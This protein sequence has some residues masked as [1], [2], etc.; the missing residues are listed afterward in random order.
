[1]L[2]KIVRIDTDE[3]WP[4]LWSFLW[5]F[6]LLCG[7]Y[8]IRP[9]RDTLASDI[10]DRENLFLYTFLATL[11]ASPV[12][13]GMV[14]TF[15]RR[16]IVG[17]AYG[18]FAT[19]LVLFCLLF[20][21]HAGRIPLTISRVF[22]VWI[23][24]YNMFVVSIFWS[25][26]TDVFTSSQGKRLFA[27]IAAGGTLGSICGAA[28]TTAYAR[29]V[30]LS[31]LVLPSIALLCAS[32][33]FSALLNKSRPKSTTVVP[34]DNATAHGALGGI[35]D[36]IREVLRTPYLLGICGFLLLGLTCA[37]TVYLQQFPIINATLPDRQDR[38][39]LFAMM[40]FGV[41][42]LTLLIQI[43]AT[44]PLLRWLGVAL[45]FCLVPLCYVFAF[46][47][48]AL[49]PSLPVIVAAVIGQR[50]LEFGMAKP[51]RELL[52]TV[53]SRGQRYKA[54]NFIDTSVVRGGDVLA[55]RLYGYLQKTQELSVPRI[56]LMMI[57]MAL[58]WTTA[59]WF[60]GRAQV[61]RAAQLE[62][63]SQS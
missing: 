16:R 33:V 12:Y 47:V 40:D 18:V 46:G 5:F 27:V 43:V 9:I 11:V 45:T 2:R 52:F 20:M 1:L 24:V 42:I 44:A 29:H 49:S 14:S 7:Y 32:I 25:F 23:G 4:L 13:S 34:A 59:S 26:V 57:P 37:M 50:A 61:R 53:V 3:T 41:N 21:R 30:Q 38:T 28:F 63:V 48:V 62:M 56:A 51:V 22:F 35:F 8:V 10:P 36:G 6:C 54:K 55:G 15:G 58:A 19:C 31:T 60:L 39:Q 17:I